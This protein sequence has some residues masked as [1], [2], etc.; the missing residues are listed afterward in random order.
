M[1]NCMTPAEIQRLMAS[2]S[3][4][5]NP[6]TNIPH[7]GTLS[8]CQAVCLLRPLAKTLSFEPVIK[9]SC[10]SPVVSVAAN[11]DSQTKRL[12]ALDNNTCLSKACD[13]HPTESCGC[14]SEEDWLTAA[15]EV[16]SDAFASSEESSDSES[17]SPGA[18]GGRPILSARRLWPIVD[19]QQ[20]SLYRN[21]GFEPPGSDISPSKVLLEQTIRSVLGP[22]KSYFAHDIQLVC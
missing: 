22:Q 2:A 6:A 9:W 5:L 11:C 13:W 20:K 1:W 10:R 18:E 4:T 8:D 21:P 19:V 15:G 3:L 14:R 17:A 16:F 12:L 7:R